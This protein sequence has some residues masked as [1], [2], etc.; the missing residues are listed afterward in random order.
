M[1]EKSL[2]SVV[3]PT[4]RRHELLRVCLRSVVDQTYPNLEI[5]VCD[6]GD[7]ATTAAV[8]EE[9]A[10]PRV[11]YVPRRPHL[12]M[13]GN[14]FEGLRA[15]SGDYLIKIDDDDWWHSDLIASLMEPFEE[16]PKLAVTFCDH[17][18]VDGT[19]NLQLDRTDDNSQYWGRADLAEG[20]H[21]PFRHLAVAGTLPMQFCALM[22]RSALDLEGVPPEVAGVYDLWLAYL[23]S[24][25]GE[26]AW[27]VPQRLAYYRVHEGS[28]TASGR[29]RVEQATLFCLREFL[30]DPAMSAVHPLARQRIKRMSAEYALALLRVKKP[31]EA[32]RALR[33]CPGSLLSPRGAAAATMALLPSGAG[34]RVFRLFDRLTSGRA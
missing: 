6:D 20:R 17:F 13:H 10:D 21:E 14:V 25:A 24:R 18:V 8:V 34:D 5:L 22:R 33:L 29:L 27:Y 1:T 2:V 28:E 9:F 7:E 19:G 26:A 15:A 30:A 16:D 32:R 4:Y 11:T 23:T 12:G 3:I 31:R